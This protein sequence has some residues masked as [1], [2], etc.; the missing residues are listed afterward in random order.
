QQLCCTQAEQAFDICGP[1]SSGQLSAQPAV[2][3]RQRQGAQMHLNNCQRQAGGD[4]GDVASLPR[5]RAALRTQANAIDR[6]TLAARVEALPFHQAP[7]HEL[8]CGPF[9]V[10]RLAAQLAQLPLPAAQRGGGQSVG[11]EPVEQRAGAE[12]AQSLIHSPSKSAELLV[13]AV[14]QSQQ[15]KAQVA[16]VVPIR[17]LAQETGAVVRRLTFAVG[18]QNQQQA[19]AGG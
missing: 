18:G 19:R 10:I 9:L 6:R 13:G 5:R 4:L 1:A 15:G 8:G 16:Q 7:G 2:R 14:S 3:V 12:L 17:Q 11:F